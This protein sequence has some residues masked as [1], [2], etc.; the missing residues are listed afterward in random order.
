MPLSDLVEVKIVPQNRV[1][2]LF[3][4]FEEEKPDKVDILHTIGP[5]MEFT[6]ISP[7]VRRVEI[8]LDRDGNIEELDLSNEILDI[9]IN[10]EFKEKL[11]YKRPDIRVIDL[12]FNSI[13]ENNQTENLFRLSR[14]IIARIYMASNY[15]A[16]ESREGSAEYVLMKQ[17]MYD[18]FISGNEFDNNIIVE[19]CDLPYGDMY[20]YR[21]SIKL[22]FNP[23]TNKYCLHCDKEA[24][25]LP[26]R[27]FNLPF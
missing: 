19:I 21:K 23:D 15:M 16:M 10:S 7:K 17:Q 25:S 18:N 13:I 27:I 2:H 5:E 12:D 20:V 14:K 8:E 4:E 9:I 11:P 6:T 3:I 22:F 24:L 1:E 26:I